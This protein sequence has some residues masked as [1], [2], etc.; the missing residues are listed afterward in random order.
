MTTQ[1][2]PKSID[3]FKQVEWGNGFEARAVPDDLLR[4]RFAFAGEVKL[5]ADECR[6]LEKEFFAH[7]APLGDVKQTKALHS[8][9]KKLREAG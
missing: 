2:V 1:R 9:L 5:T 8:I 6:A 7:L 3:E 4:E